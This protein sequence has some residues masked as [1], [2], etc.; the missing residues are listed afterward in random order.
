[1]KLK[2]LILIIILFSSCIKFSPKLPPEPE[3]YVDFVVFKSSINEFL[4][5]VYNDKIVSKDLKNDNKFNNKIY[6][7]I[8]LNNI[9]KSHKLTIKWYLDNK[10]FKANNNIS[11]NKKNLNLEYV[12]VWDFIEKTNNKVEVITLL[13]NKLLTINKTHN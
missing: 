11:I 4:Q 13:D 3:A 5:K 9:N 2:Y 12:I 6:F 8:K 7:I 1:M 10:L